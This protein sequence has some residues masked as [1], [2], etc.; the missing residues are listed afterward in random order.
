MAVTITARGYDAN[1]AATATLTSD[2]FTPAANSVL[3]LVHVTG[4]GAEAI[5]SVSGHGTWSSVYSFAPAGWTKTIEVW[6][7]LVG[8]SPSSAQIAA[9]TGYQWRSMCEFFEASGVD[10]SGGTAA[11]CFGVS[12][13]DTLY[14]TNPTLNF[15]LGTFTVA[16]GLTFLVGAQSAVTSWP[17][18]YTTNTQRGSIA[19]AFMQ[20]AY[21]A[22][23]DNDISISATGI[24]RLSGAVFEIKGE[25]A[26]LVT[27]LKLL[28]H[29]SAASATGVEGEVFA[30]PTGG[31]IT[32]TK[33]GYFSGA[34]F[35]A[36]LEGVNAVLKVAVADFG[37]EALTTS[38]TPTALVR[39]ATLTTGAVVCSVIEE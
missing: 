19:W 3:F 39:N 20:T 12:D 15:T 7:C 11:S 22:S 1:E 23:E 34:T 32:G 24:D 29:S 6:A 33:Y 16:T 4:G 17:G 21:V 18:G 5:D 35:E 30:A 13:S 10:V 26:A 9:T 27:K 2:T 31:E 25:G 37:G 38:D 8:A 28:A 36:S 14:G